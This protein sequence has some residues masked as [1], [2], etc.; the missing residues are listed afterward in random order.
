M[1]FSRSWGNVGTLGRTG[2]LTCPIQR[3]PVPWC[4]EFDS[5]DQDSGEP[6]LAGWVTGDVKQHGTGRTDECPDGWVM[7]GWGDR[8][9]T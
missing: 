6:R 7:T 8:M 1:A 4:L 5:Y 9:Y 3:F 2:R